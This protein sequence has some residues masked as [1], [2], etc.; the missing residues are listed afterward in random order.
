MDRVYIPVRTITDGCRAFALNRAVGLS[1]RRLE[2]AKILISGQHGC[3]VL[4][5]SHS[6]IVGAILMVL[7]S[8]RKLE[9]RPSSK[10]DIPLKREPPLL[11]SYGINCRLR[12]KSFGPHIL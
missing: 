10:L 7:H 6:R 9:K 12:D 5:I 1:A 4:T 2:P 3:R 11:S 8:P